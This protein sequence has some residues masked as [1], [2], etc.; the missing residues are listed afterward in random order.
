MVP[1]LLRALHDKDTAERAATSLVAAADDDPAAAREVLKQC[2]SLPEYKAAPAHARR[3]R[4]R[5]AAHVCR[6]AVYGLS[7]APV[8]AQSLRFAAA[9]LATER[10]R[11]AASDLRALVGALAAAVAGH[12]AKAAAEGSSA[13]PDGA[14]LL[15]TLLIDPL[16]R[17]IAAAVDPDAK[18]LG[19]RCVAA[20]VYEC[21]IAVE[22]YA[23]PLSLNALAATL[24]ATG[25]ARPNATPPAHGEAASLAALCLSVVGSATPAPDVIVHAVAR[26]ATGA[27]GHRGDYRVREKGAAAA[28]A[29]AD[30]ASRH[31]T[32]AAALVGNDAGEEVAHAL[33]VSLSAA[34]FDKVRHVREGVQRA[35]DALRHVLGDAVDSALGS[36]A[37]ARVPLG[38][39]ERRRAAAQGGGAESP[40]VE[41]YV[42]GAKAP[43]DADALPET[44]PAEASQAMR[45]MEARVAAL[46]RRGRG[47]TESTT[48]SRPSPARSPP[49]QAS[50]RSGPQG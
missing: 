20:A 41:I 31:P 50:P 28:R 7:V 5:V 35:T 13:G 38:V 36:P 46:A 43:L 44:L 29:L 33:A 40:R 18:A 27:V 15:A 9:L 23:A 3:A 14:S 39:A 11:G 1:R 34:R 45:M 30:H 8:V 2:L 22:V 48:P 25:D 16:V 37:A 12:A 26:L 47:H 17:G 6:T 4:L 24:A 10:D 49:P 19:C 32:V 21:A 42:P